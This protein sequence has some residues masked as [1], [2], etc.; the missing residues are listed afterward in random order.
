MLLINPSMIVLL[1]AQLGWMLI[2]GLQ[3]QAVFPEVF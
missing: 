2:V 1:R 3:E